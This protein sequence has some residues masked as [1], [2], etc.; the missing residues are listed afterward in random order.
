MSQFD[1]L[2][3]DKWITPVE[4]EHRHTGLRVAGVIAV[5]LALGAAGYFLLW[6]RVRE[7][8]KDDRVHTEQAVAS[9][10][11]AA[12]SAPAPVDL[13]PLAQSDAMVRELVGRLSAHPSVTAWLSTDQLIRNF[14]VVVHNIAGG[15]NPSRL[16]S[17]VKP[18]GT[19]QAI[20]RDG[21]L[22]IDPRSHR[23]YDTYAAAISGLDAQGAAQLYGT[24]KPRIEEAYRELGY[25][26]GGFDKVLQRAVTDLLKTP[27]LDGPVTLVRKSV[28]YEYADPA[29]QSLSPAQRQ[30][31]RMGPQ[32]VRAIQAKVREIAPLLGLTVE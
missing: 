14:T 12:P 23:R 20:E 25:P 27:V 30:F 4:P 28:V 32:N 10:P 2:H 5:L 31:L 22:R 8:P 6:P 21:V 7:A 17:K 15:R 11:V 18:V 24:L 1:D 13:P 9:T 29:L 19:F 16:L 26:E 3:L